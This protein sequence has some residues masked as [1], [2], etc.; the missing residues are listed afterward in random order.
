MTE[1]SDLYGR[2]FEHF[3]LNEVR[4]YIEYRKLEKGISYWR[5]SSG[6]EVDL[7]VGEMELAL[8]FKADKRVRVEDLKGLR[9]LSDEHR[10]GRMLVVA[11]EER[12]LKTEDGIEIVPWR[13]FCAKLWAG[14]LV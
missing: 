14:E 11:R 13:E 6:F 4:A 9:A 1:G 3:L 10:P 2:A 5:T 12:A 8:E 7:I